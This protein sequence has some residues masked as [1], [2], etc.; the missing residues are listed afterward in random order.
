MAAKREKEIKIQ[1]SKTRTICSVV[2]L[3]DEAKNTDWHPNEAQG[4]FKVKSKWESAIPKIAVFALRESV[5]R[6]IR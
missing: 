1:S 2:A 4:N 5:G 6:N 3:Q